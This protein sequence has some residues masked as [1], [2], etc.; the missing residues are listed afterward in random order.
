MVGWLSAVKSQSAQ[1]Y[2]INYDYNQSASRNFLLLLRDWPKKN[3]S[4]I[5]RRNRGPRISRLIL[6]MKHQGALFPAMR[7]CH[8]SKSMSGPET[9]MLGQGSERARQYG[10]PAGGAHSNGGRWDCIIDDIRKTHCRKKSPLGHLP[11]YKH[12][13][14]RDLNVKG[15]TITNKIKS[16]GRISLWPWDG[17]RN[18]KTKPQRPPKAQNIRWQHKA[19]RM[20]GYQVTREWLI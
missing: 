9:S 7:M 4:R 18:C 17:K 16:C 2:F 11:H 10:K 3:N 8:N 20:T 13:A 1:A 12:R 14:I 19:D 6:K 5:K 15:I